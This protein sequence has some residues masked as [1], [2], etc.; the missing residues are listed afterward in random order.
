MKVL[1]L[2]KYGDAGPSSRYRFYNYQPYFEEAG[3][4]CC[5]KPLL[6]NDYV[7]SLYKK[8]KVKALVKSL[9]SVFKRIFFLLFNLKEYDLIIIEKE[10][11]P[12]VPYFVEAYLLKSKLYALDFDD[13]VATSYKENK[14]K[15]FFFENK[16]QNL[17]AKAKLVTVGNHWYFEELKGDNL[18]YLPTVVDL[19]KYA[20]PKQYNE[21][22]ILTIV[23]I[24]SPSTAKYLQLV[25]SALEKLAE[26]YTIKLKIIGAN[27]NIE[28]VEV[29]LVSWDSTTE[30]E[31]LLSADIGIMPLTRT[32]WEN[33]KCGFKL[34]QYMASGL[35]VVATSVPA[36]EEIV[37]DDING[38]IVNNDEDWYN[39]LETLIVNRNLR[40]QFGK[41]G[42]DRIE[43][44]YS[45]QVWG[46]RY[47]NIIKNG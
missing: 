23:W 32:M 2:T 47:V 33:G 7:Y 5:F 29:E 42:R 16:I 17:V 46:N 19:E 1:F 31:E 36:N 27:I 6:S 37:E 14:I 21:V 34:I 10:L 8:Q 43:N 24:G 20:K 12:N 41:S 35:P 30:A 38:F 28:K 26:K 39:K 25:A 4:S 22:D 44:Y 11:F 15:S 3:I 18:R 40:E 13:Y 45:Y 9:F